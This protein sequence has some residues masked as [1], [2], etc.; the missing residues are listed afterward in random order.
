MQGICA[1]LSALVRALSKACLAGACLGTCQVKQLLVITLI[2]IS[3]RLQQSLPLALNLCISTALTAAVEHHTR[4][5]P[6][7]LLAGVTW[8][9][10]SG[11]ALRYAA[12]PWQ[13]G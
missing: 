7:A 4:L 8:L 11:Q 5:W 3:S 12:G 10:L 2:T 1:D 13:S 6:C 9:R